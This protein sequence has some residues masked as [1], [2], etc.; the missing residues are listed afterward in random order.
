MEK[1]KE[2]ITEEEL[3][4]RGKYRDSIDILLSRISML[5]GED[6]LLMTMYWENGNSLRQI[7]RLAGI[8]R[9]SIARRI[10]KAT[11]RLMEG[12]YITCL[13]NR[14]RFTRRQMAV[15]KEYYLLGLSIKAIAEK[16]KLS[17]YRV[18]QILNKIQRIIKT[19]NSE[20]QI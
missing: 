5:T 1:V 16:R 19:I 4:V 3:Q 9:L 8:N 12:Q 2:D 7:G 18:R 10:N 17:L 6:K 14:D 13:R 15:A 20:M 11:R